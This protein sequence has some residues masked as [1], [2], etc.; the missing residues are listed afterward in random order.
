MINIGHRSLRLLHNDIKQQTVND[1]VNQNDKKYYTH[2]CY[3]FL[4]LLNKFQGFFNVFY[5]I[6]FGAFSF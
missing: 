3:I 1:S 2:L 4:T 5:T 6:C